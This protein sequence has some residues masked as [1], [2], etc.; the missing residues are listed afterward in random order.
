[1]SAIINPG[2]TTLA[3]AAGPSDVQNAKTNGATPVPGSGRNATPVPSAGRQEARTWLKNLLLAPSASDEQAQ[4]A[5][6]K[7]REIESQCGGYVL[8]S[9]VLAFLRGLSIEK[10]EDRSVHIDRGFGFA[11]ELLVRH[12]Y[13][14]LEDIEKRGR[15][16]G[17]S[18]FEG[19]CSEIIDT[20]F[21]RV[22]ARKGVEALLTM[23]E[24]LLRKASELGEHWKLYLDL[25][26]QAVNTTVDLTTIKLEQEESKAAAA[27]RAIRT[28]DPFDS[29]VENYIPSVDMELMTYLRDVKLKM[30]RVTTTFEKNAREFFKRQAKYS[31]SNNSPAQNSPAPNAQ[32]PALVKPDRRELLETLHRAASGI[33]FHPYT[34]IMCERLGLAAEET[35]RGT[36]LKWF[37][38]AA[39]Y[40]ELHADR[41]ANH[42][43]HSLAKARY[44]RAGHHYLA[45]GD[46]TAAQ[47]VQEK[48]TLGAV[49]PKA[50]AAPAQ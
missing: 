5:L 50:A 4:Q 26:N 30:H 11:A 47:R 27:R 23:N 15:L 1:M 22:H 25:A 42:K 24:W 9:D 12:V 8:A 13:V 29:P 36:G 19:Y 2:S 35:E 41:D 33:E 10:R 44:R 34:A 48:F 45:A 20:L 14:Q 49:R 17:P 32:Q 40:H 16:L 28:A 46:Q 39:G 7:L 18:I 21:S 37:K 31:K 6:T 3:K 43:L 38:A